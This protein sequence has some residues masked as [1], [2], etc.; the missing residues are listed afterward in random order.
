M[1]SSKPPLLTA[2]AV[3][4]NILNEELIR[5]IHVYRLEDG[6]EK[7]VEREFMFS[8]SSYVEMVAHP[9]IKFPKYRELFEGKMIGLWLCMLAFDIEVSTISAPIPSILTISR[10]PKLKSIPTLANDLQK[11]FQLR[12]RTKSNEVA[13]FAPVEMCR[14]NKDNSYHSTRTVPIFHEDHYSL[15]HPIAAQ[16]S[17]GSQQIDQRV[18]DLVKKKKRAAAEH[19]AS[20]ALS[21]LAKYFDLPITEASRNLKVGLTVLKR[22]CREFGIPRWP[23]RKIKSLDTLIHDL[24]EEAERQE[25]ENKAAAMAVMKRQRMLEREKE[26]I[27]TMPFMEIQGLQ[28]KYQKDPSEKKPRKEREQSQRW[29]S[30]STCR[31]QIRNDYGPTRL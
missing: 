14:E 2:L 9:L 19:I 24:Q 16:G 17:L 20:I 23:H 3:F 22:K 11:V 12:C 31:N 10:N 1:D 7:I 18:P 5:S 25:R 6:K 21:D 4:K 15:P 27:E 28:N 13:K 26:G 8:P 29:V 30:K